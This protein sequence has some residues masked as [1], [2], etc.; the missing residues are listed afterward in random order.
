MDS[1][2]FVMIAKQ[3]AVDEVVRECVKELKSPR[4]P[5]GSPAPRSLVEE[6][7]RQWL[8]DRSLVEQRRSDWFK[9]LAEDDQR[10]MR[11]ILEE[12]A[13]KVLASFFCLVDG[14][15]GNYEGVFEIVAVEE[16]RREVLNPQNT[17]MLHDIF[18][19]VCEEGR[20]KN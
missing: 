9:R 16:E 1:C 11:N 17:E 13:E 7:I 3:Y 6:S 12:C 10:L 4:P 20:R 15:G 2:E 8:N 19:D 5:K 14:V 18:S